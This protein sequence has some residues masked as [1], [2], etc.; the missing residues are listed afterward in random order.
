MSKIKTHEMLIPSSMMDGWQRIVN[1]L[2]EILNVPSALIMRASQQ[3]LEIFCKNTN[4]DNP[5][6]TGHKEPLGQGLYC[7]T[8]MQTQQELLVPNAL[9]DKKWMHNPDVPLGMIAYCGIPLKWPNGDMFGTICVLDSKENHFSPTY[10]QLLES[11]RD[12]IESQLTT[13]YQQVRLQQLNDELQLR[14]DNRTQDLADLNYSLT[15]EIDKRRAAEQ[16]IQYQKWHDI[17][18]GFLNRNALELELKN[19]LLQATKQ[20][21]EVA[22]I[23]IGFTNARHIQSHFGY[24]AW[25]QVIARYRERLG[26][27]DKIEILTARPTSTDLVL[28]VKTKLLAR[29]LEKLC[30]KLVEIGHS[31]FKLDDHNV[32]LHSYVGIATSLDTDNAIELL[33]QASAAMVSCKDSGHK[34]CYHSQVFSDSLR[35]INQLESYLLRAVRNDELMLYFQPKVSPTTH[36]WTGAEALLRWRHPVLGDISNET[37]IHMAEQNGLIFEVGNF[38]LRSAIEKTSQWA[39]QVDNF[40]MAINVSA[41]QLKNAQFADQVRELLNTYQLPARYL[42][43]EVTESCLIADEVVARNTLRILHQL[44]V[45]LSLDDFGTGYASFSYLKK[46]PFDCIKIDKSFVHQLDQ[47]EED[48][49]IVRSIIHVA[50]KLKLKVILEGIENQSQEDFI[51]SE[52]CEFGQGYFYGKPMPC[53]EFEAGLLNQNY[54]YPVETKV[55]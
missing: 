18:T 26:R 55:L 52:G 43:L 15:Q 46:F 11:F 50:K 53:D 33:K 31:E 45:T 28:I 23:H 8:V 48:K 12:T 40:K 19:S 35:Q 32:H 17:S 27:C 1:L 14:V 21:T 25:D 5:Y 51:I 9:A 36:R 3:K 34:F 47:S 16:Q 20:H 42:E 10:R 30:H 37:L 13:L 49:E 38:V 7:E 2:A 22:A 44:G 39:K 24:R 6:Q 4:V 41:V 54:A 29:H